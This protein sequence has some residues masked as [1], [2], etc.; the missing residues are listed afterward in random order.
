[1]IQTIYA[2][3]AGGQET[4]FCEADDKKSALQLALQDWGISIKAAKEL[5]ACARDATGGEVYRYCRS[6]CISMD[7]LVKHPK[8]GEFRA[9]SYH[10]DDA[11]LQA[12]MEWN[13]DFDEALRKECAV[14]VSRRRVMQ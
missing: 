11:I 10:K 3:D 1:M 2:V 9:P 4:F 14:Y 8:H 5:G 12:S 7:M 13:V 6:K